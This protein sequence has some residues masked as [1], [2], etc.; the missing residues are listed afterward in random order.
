M[1][2]S[3]S[4]RSAPSSV[5]ALRFAHT[6]SP[7]CAGAGATADGLR[8]ARWLAG[9]PAPMTLLASR[10]PSRP[11]VWLQ[12]FV[13]SEASGRGWAV[14]HGAPWPYW[15]LRGSGVKPLR[16]LPSP[17][18]IVLR[19]A[20]IHHPTA[21]RVQRSEAD[22][23]LARLLVPRPCNSPLRSCGVLV[24]A[25]LHLLPSVLLATARSFAPSA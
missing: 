22:V 1:A 5:T 24:G 6:R 8:E 25:L 19:R 18:P 2:N 14:D 21:S 9:L 4:F 10:A 3:I 13:F 16:P 23:T 7:W 15:S 11:C 17:S 20:C 12:P